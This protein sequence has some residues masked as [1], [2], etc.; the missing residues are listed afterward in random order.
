M[1]SCTI[2]LDTV[3]S[4]V[5]LPCGHVFC[6][7]CIVNMVGS[8][9]PYTT[10]QC[11][12][13][14]RASYS[15]VNIDP[16][17]VP[18]YLRSSLLPS[19]RRI[20]LDEIPTNADDVPGELARL[21]AENISLKSQCEGWKARAY[22]HRAS[23]TGLAGLAKITREYAL[24]MKAEKEEIEAKYNLLKHSH[25]SN[26]EPPI[27]PAPSTEGCNSPVVPAHDPANPCLWLHLVDP[28]ASIPSTRSTSPP[29]MKKMKKDPTFVSSPDIP[30]T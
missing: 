11:C 7:E 4:P 13:S 15:I 9:L 3:K 23:V 28:P 25:E 18:T 5:A 12:P 10:K 21:R 2:C 16:S 30:S 26:S 14:C 22:Y 19:L 24:R 27:T 29:P 20:Y 1:P 17:I 8:I 6:H